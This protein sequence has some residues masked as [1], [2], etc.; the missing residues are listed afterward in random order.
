MGFQQIPE[1]D[2][3]FIPGDSSR[4]YNPF[5]KRYINFPIYFDHDSVFN[6]AR[7]WFRLREASK[8]SLWLQLLQVEH[9]KVLKDRSNVYMK[10]YSEAF[11]KSA[12]K[13]VEQA[14]LPKPQDSLYIEKLA[15]RAN[16]NPGN[17]DSAFAAA[18]P[19]MF[20]SAN[21]NILV[22][23]EIPKRTFLDYKPSDA[24]MH[25]VYNITI[26]KAYKDFVYEFGAVVDEKGIIRFGEL[27]TVVEDVENRKAVLNAIIKLYLQPMLK[28]AP[29]TTLG[30]KHSSSIILKV[31][32]IK[33]D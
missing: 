18:N 30:F 25:P 26:Q 10:F 8:D 21:P 16:R 27:L 31:K 1:W 3:Y 23:R 32:G 7:Q 29:G 24:Y 4:I 12:G 2:M 17:I 19:V 20:E 5:E 22:E 28:V 9:K 11:L 14:R 6:T 33:A 13:S 15:G